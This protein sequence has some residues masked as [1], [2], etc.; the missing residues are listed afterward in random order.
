MTQRVRARA[1]TQCV[2]SSRLRV[3]RAV[4]MR[5][6]AQS[7]LLWRPQSIAA[8]SSAAKLDRDVPTHDAESLSVYGALLLRGAIAA[9]E[10]GDR[11]TAHELLAEA[12][13]T[14]TR[15]GE[16]R[17]LRWTAFGPTNAKLHQVNIAVTPGDAGTAID[18]A[19]TVNLSNVTVTERQAS[20]LVDTT[21]AFLQCSKPD[22]AYL[23][24]RA[25]EEMAPEDIAGRPA[26]HRLVHD[27]I[28]SAPPS[29]RSRAED[30][31]QRIGIPQ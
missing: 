17:N 5:A 27:L 4:R 2:A 6:G 1:P 14:A 9:A 28:V 26:V 30:F 7:R 29:T 23:A 12:G 10:H 13:D 16:D 3:Y 21:R 31:A 8:S 20:F 24:L 25:A 19:R 18:V 11:H 15:L 22:K